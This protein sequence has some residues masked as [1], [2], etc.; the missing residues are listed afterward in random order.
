MFITL[1]RAGGPPGII[2]KFNIKKEEA[3]VPATFLLK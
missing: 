1:E 3:P 2:F